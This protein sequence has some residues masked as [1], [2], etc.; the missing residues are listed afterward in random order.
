MPRPG[1]AF[2]LALHLRCNGLHEVNP[3]A[4]SQWHPA[5]LSRR[6]QS[7]FRAALAVTDTYEVTPRSASHPGPAARKTKFTLTGSQSLPSRRSALP[8][9]RSLDLLE[10]HKLWISRSSRTWA[11]HTR[12]WPERSR[13]RRLSAQ[14][15]NLIGARHNSTYSTMATYSVVPS[16]LHRDLRTQ[17]I[18]KYPSPS[19]EKTRW[20]DSVNNA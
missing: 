6:R 1:N 7:K 3:N 8:S 12:G 19:D 20:E 11:P 15:F 2:D 16:P 9:W 10:L 14:A 13:L 18:I 17:L 5:S 4:P